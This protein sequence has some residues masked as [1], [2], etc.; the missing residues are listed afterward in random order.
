MSAPYPLLRTPLP[1]YIEWKG[2]SVDHGQQVVVSTLADHI[3]THRGLGTDIAPYPTL[4]GQ[5]VRLGRKMYCYQKYKQPYH[6]PPQI[7]D[8]ALIARFKDA[9]G[10]QG[11]AHLQSFG[12][13]S[14]G[15]WYNAG[16]L[17]G[18]QGMTGT[19]HVHLH[20]H[21]QDNAGVHH[22]V[23]WQLE[24]S[25]NL[26]FNVGVSGVNIRLSPGLAGVVWG[27]CQVA[28]I[29]RK[30]GKVVAAHSA[31]LVRR[32]VASI[33]KDGY[34]WMPFHIANVVEPL[35]TARPFI[36]FV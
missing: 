36:H 34:E 19:S 11:F 25:R 12:P 10:N 24:Q 28:S 26:Q 16:Q 33:I 35:W 15:V 7:G 17:V 29:V 8:G 5:P 18:Y 14:V 20:T 27:T 3:A 9:T 1:G 31:T 32:H 30:D 6:N 23:Y 2:A 4:P 21:W 22:E 13:I